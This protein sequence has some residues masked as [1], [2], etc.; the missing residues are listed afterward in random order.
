M[1]LHS[2]N[3]L[4]AQMKRTEELA[5]SKAERMRQQCE[6]D[7]RM[8]MD[9]QA[10]ARIGRAWESPLMFS[11]GADSSGLKRVGQRRQ[12]QQQHQNS[13][14]SEDDTDSDCPIFERP[15]FM[16]KMKWAT[17]M[18]TKQVSES[19]SQPLDLMVQGAEQLLPPSMVEEGD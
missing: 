2:R 18:A 6:E 7:D 8:R 15:F 3:L 17:T 12:E 1:Q 9:D 5:E 19:R 10:I 14:G 13:F 16:A 11:C 4:Q